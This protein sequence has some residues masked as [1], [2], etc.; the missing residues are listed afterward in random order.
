MGS[1]Q[2]IYKDIEDALKRR[3]NVEEFIN[4][5]AQFESHR[6]EPAALRDFLESFALLE[7]EDRDEDADKDAVTFSTV[8]AAKGLEFPVVFLV[9]LEQGMFPHERALAE[10]G[11]DEELRLFYVALTRAKEE[12]YLLHSRSRLQRG[13]PHPERPSPFL[14]M[15]GKEL[16]DDNSPEELVRPVDTSR[17]IEAFKRIYERLNRG[18]DDKMD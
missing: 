1:L 14:T 18:N 3:D 13:V 10:G 7:E 6:S 4:G 12:L 5:A 15:L 11:G 16:V 8:H 9:A 2:R 17:A